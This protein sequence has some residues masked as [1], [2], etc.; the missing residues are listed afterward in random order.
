MHHNRELITDRLRLR[1]LRL[2]DAAELFP[3]FSHEAA[4]RYWDTPP[5][6][7]PADTEGMIA[8]LQNENACW[9]A[10]CLLES[11]RPIGLVGYLGNPGVPGMGYILHP[12]Y[13]RQGLMTEA[14]RAAVAYGFEQ[15]DLDR[16]EFW[17]VAENR[18]S[19]RLALK[20]GGQP[21]GQFRQKFAH[22][23]T[24]H[25]NIVYG[26]YASD[27][28]QPNARPVPPEREQRFYQVQPVLYV[29]DVQQAAAFYCD[30]LGFQLDFLYGDPPDHGAVSSGE[31]TTTGVTIQLARQA[32]GNH[33]GTSNVLLYVFV[34]PDI[35][36]LYQRYKTK[37]VTI[38][39]SIAT[40][41]W[42]MREFT[43]QDLNG[44]RLRFGTAI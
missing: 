14:V 9:W 35:D 27:W 38:T 32:D 19:R 16:L 8:I 36:G 33:S 26:I 23:E 31:W 18:P 39:E 17:I 6:Q 29:P 43:I 15:M 44:Q 34:G 2:T 24:A 5:H 10:V 20:V 13:W 28:P 41:P 11:D 42:G 37:K 25:E 1:P 7:S 3:I 22:H 12:G 30:Q 40:Y 21:V 4:M